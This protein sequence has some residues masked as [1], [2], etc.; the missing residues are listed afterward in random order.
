MKAFKLFRSKKQTGMTLIEVM[1]SLAILAIVIGGA[2]ALFSSASGSQAATQMTT[3]LSAIRSNV[4]SLWNGQG[5]YTVGS[6]NATMITANKVPMTMTTATPNITN[7]YGGA[8]VITGATTVFTVSTAA[9]PID[10]CTSLLS[11]ARGWSQVQVTGGVAQTSFP[12]QPATAAGQCALGTVV[13]FTS[14]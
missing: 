2:L 1:S 7:N 10:V 9:I 14:T 12:I 5:A 11:S 3:D 4:K 6:L 13:T 8:V